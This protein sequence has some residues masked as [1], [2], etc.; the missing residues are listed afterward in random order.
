MHSDTS[1]GSVEL[2]AKQC[3]KMRHMARLNGLLD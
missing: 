3:T 1:S 2:S